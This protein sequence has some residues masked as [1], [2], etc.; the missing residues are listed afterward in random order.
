MSLPKPRIRI[1]T[2]YENMWIASWKIGGLTLQASGPDPR[3]AFHRLL[4]RPSVTNE[5]GYR[6][7]CRP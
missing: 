6:M 2:V 7:E 1:S 5:R 4:T 3:A